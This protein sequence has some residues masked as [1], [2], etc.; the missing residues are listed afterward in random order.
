MTHPPTRGLWKLGAAGLTALLLALGAGRLSAQANRN[1]T[2]AGLVRNP[3]LTGQ[4]L[5]AEARRQRAIQIQA[6]QKGLL[7][8]L[9]Y[10]TDLAKDLDLDDNAS[11][12]DTGDRQLRQGTI[13]L[14]N[15]AGDRVRAI[16]TFASEF[17][18]LDA[19]G[20]EDGTD[21]TQVTDLFFEGDGQARASGFWNVDDG[22]G[23][24]ALH[25]DGTTG[26]NAGIRRY[27][28]GQF[29]FLDVIS[30]TEEL[31]FLAR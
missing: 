7:L 22:A 5:S 21:L 19:S 31:W 20:E 6:T 12:L 30:D 4:R 3:A 25:I 10:D 13:W 28:N 18:F 29:F 11:F 24:P 1:P 8:L 14:S 23:S 15:R 9:E 16:G 17:Q 2:R 26:R 27:N